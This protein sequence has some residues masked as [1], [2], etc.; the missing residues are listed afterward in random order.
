VHDRAW[1]RICS[2]ASG[3]VAQTYSILVIMGL[4]DDG[5]SRNETCT[6]ISI[7][8]FFLPSL[9]RY[10]WW[11]TISPW[12]YN[13][14][15]SQCFNHLVD[16]SAGGLLFSEGNIHPVVRV[17]ALTW[18]IWYYWGTISLW[19]YNPP[20]SPCFG[21]DMVYLISLGDYQSL[22]V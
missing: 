21:T 15:S 6:L 12:G 4:P 17:S 9:G 2:Y 22:R 18:F 19:G 7:S 1:Q 20:S 14:P 16:T 8:T 13:P 5:Y 11:W 3:C 10:L